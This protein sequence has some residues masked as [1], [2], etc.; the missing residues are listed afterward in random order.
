MSIN[1]RYCLAYNWITFGKFF[2]MI[3]QL[4]DN[5]L[6]WVP[7]WWLHI[8]K[9][10][11]KVTY[12]GN[13]LF[14]N[15]ILHIKSSYSIFVINFSLGLVHSSLV[16][17]YLSFNMFIDFPLSVYYIYHIFLFKFRSEFI[18]LGLFVFMFSFVLMNIHNVFALWFKCVSHPSDS[19]IS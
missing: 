8:T 2:L 1:L 14:S 12:I 16:Q 10:V 11:V 13:I 17:D 7:I 18:S 6:L 19:F 9:W 4:Y 5:C 15:T 3:W